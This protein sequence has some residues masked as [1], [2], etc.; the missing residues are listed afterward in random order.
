MTDISVS[1]DD[2]FTATHTARET[3]MADREQGEPIPGVADYERLLSAYKGAV[4][5][6]Y[7]ISPAYASEEA[8]AAMVN[9]RKELDAYVERLAADA[10]RLRSY[11]M[12]CAG[13]GAAAVCVGPMGP[14]CEECC[15]HDGAGEEHCVALLAAHDY[16][17]QTADVRTMELLTE[18]A[19]AL[20]GE[21][22]AELLDALEA[23]L[24]YLQQEARVTAL[25]RRH[26]RAPS[27]GAEQGEYGVE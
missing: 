13:C 23:A 17:P 3:R 7:G 26:G 19:A 16:R 9:A 20:A 12:W 18:A 2:W 4:V 22:D 8:E 24:M 5:M 11:P 6:Y 1:L 14:M 21:P 10:E 25:L 15:G 27:G